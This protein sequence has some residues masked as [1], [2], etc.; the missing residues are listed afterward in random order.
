[1]SSSVGDSK[2][3]M[4]KPRESTAEKSIKE[5]K[6][7]SPTILACSFKANALGD[8]DQLSHGKVEILCN[9]SFI[10]FI[11][12]EGGEGTQLFSLKMRQRRVL[13]L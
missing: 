10:E 9:I 3:T 13:F 6:V 8:V 1:M 4:N 11:I 2:E 12:E 5:R 7:V